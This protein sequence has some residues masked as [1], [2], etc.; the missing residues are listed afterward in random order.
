MRVG[1]GFPAAV[2][3]GIALVDVAGGE[4]GGEL[5]DRP[6]VVLV[7]AVQLA[8]QQ[9]VQHVVVVVVPLGGVGIGIAAGLVGEEA[10]L[11][12][13][14]LQHQMHMAVGR[15]TLVHGLRQLREDVGGAVVADGVHRIEAQPVEAERLQPV[16]GVGDEKVAHRPL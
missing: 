13:V 5:V 16:D 12:G 11:V 7:V 2:A 6:L 3:R 4:R 14:V 10:R 1:R 9:H 15:Q 8:G